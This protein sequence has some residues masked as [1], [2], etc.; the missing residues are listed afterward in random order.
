M[1]WWSTRESFL[2]SNLICRGNTDCMLPA[3]AGFVCDKAPPTAAV[4]RPEIKVTLYMYKVQ[5]Y[6]IIIM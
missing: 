1:S 3:E 4:L 5:L 2:S 6:R